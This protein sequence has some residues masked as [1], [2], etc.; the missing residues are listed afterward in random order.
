MK[1]IFKL[2]AFYL[3]MSLISA[4]ITYA[5]QYNAK[6][7]PRGITFNSDGATNTLE[8]ELCGPV[9]CTFVSD[10]ELNMLGIDLGGNAREILA[11]LQKMRESEKIW[12]L[13]QLN[14]LDNLEDSTY[15]K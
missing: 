10:P 9:Y 5:E 6:L 1:F 14:M 11:T 12:L 8:A 13:N 4:N 3:F 15:Q 7:A 2:S